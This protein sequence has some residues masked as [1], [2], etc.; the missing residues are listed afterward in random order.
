MKRLLSIVGGKAR[1]LVVS[2]LLGVGCRN[3]D[4]T[5][6][7]NHSFV[8]PLCKCIA[9]THEGTANVFTSILFLQGR[10]YETATAFIFPVASFPLLRQITHVDKEG[11]RHVT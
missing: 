4:L 11:H 10:L 5:F 9:F 8:L 6:F 1:E 7:L 3:G 2:H